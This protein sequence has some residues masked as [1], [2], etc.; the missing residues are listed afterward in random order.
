MRGDDS[1]LA[2]TAGRETRSINL[3][4]FRYR[5]CRC[6]RSSGLRVCDW[7]D[8]FDHN[9]ASDSEWR[10]WVG[11]KRWSMVHRCLFDTSGVREDLLPRRGWDLIE[12]QGE[13]QP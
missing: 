10:L 8:W 4:I 2:D 3:R 5:L 13:A 7:S 1:A 12:P 9:R 11:V 6:G